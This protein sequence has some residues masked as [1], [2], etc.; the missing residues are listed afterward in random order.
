MHCQIQITRRMPAL[1]RFQP[2]A[3]IAEAIAGPK[4][5]LCHLVGDKKKPRRL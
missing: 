4:L 5:N 3:N 1:R 2:A